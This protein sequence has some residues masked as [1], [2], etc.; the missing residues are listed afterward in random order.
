MNRSEQWVILLRHGIAEARGSI[1]D[2]ERELTGKGRR[3]MRRSARALTRLIPAVDAIASSPLQRC[4]QTAHLV[5][6]RTRVSEV[7]LLDE[8]QP[9]AEP[10]GFLRYLRETESSTIVC[11]GHEPLLSRIACALLGIESNS[12]LELR[13]GGCY[14]F[15]ICSGVSHLEWMLA[16]RVLRSIR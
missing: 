14:V 1:P 6:A 10:E 9:Q 16:P 5:A 11:V 15:T 12:G 8:L 13:K 3:R 7:E 4:V 2:E